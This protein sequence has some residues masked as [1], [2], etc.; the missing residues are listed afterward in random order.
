VQ[1]DCFHDAPPGDRLHC[2][3][4]GDE[5]II[6]V[7]PGVSTVT[8]WFGRS[9]VVLLVIIAL[10]GAGLE[11]GGV[12][13][14]CERNDWMLALAFAAAS[15]MSTI[16]YWL[17]A[18]FG[19]TFLIIEPDRLLIQRRVLGTR[20]SRQYQLASYSKAKLAPTHVFNDTPIYSVSVAAVEDH[21]RFADS[22]SLEEQIWLVRRINQHLG[23]DDGSDPVIERGG[24]PPQHWGLMSGVE[25][26]E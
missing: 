10:I 26:G 7:L 12:F 5:L 21:P 18:R 19:K 22:L 11:F 17:T 13:P 9:S 2:E 20:L 16:G 25:F 4:Q 23:Q 24:E 15:A 1:T 14:D 3:L 8:D 6:A